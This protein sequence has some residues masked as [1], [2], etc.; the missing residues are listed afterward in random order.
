MNK[1]AKLLFLLKVFQKLW[2]SYIQE[3]KLF[4][5]SVVGSILEY[6]TYV[7]IGSE[8]LKK[9][10]VRNI[11]RELTYDEYIYNCKRTCVPIGTKVKY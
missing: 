10:A 8:R 4:Y 2:H 3:L 7:N 1:A 5:T 9:L 11:F 6:C